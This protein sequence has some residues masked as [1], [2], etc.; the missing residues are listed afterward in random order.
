VGILPHMYA[1]M[2]GRSSLALARSISISRFVTLVKPTSRTTLIQLY[3][4]QRYVYY[5]ALHVDFDKSPF[6]IW[7]H[8]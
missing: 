3:Y 1:C 6:Q 7:A 8:D 4:F 2:Y 5:S